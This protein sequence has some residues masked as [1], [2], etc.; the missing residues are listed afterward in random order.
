MIKIFWSFCVDIMK[1]FSQVQDGVESSQRSSGCSA[2]IQTSSPLVH[3]GWIC[4]ALVPSFYTEG[5]AEI[6]YTLNSITKTY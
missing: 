5:T 4:V 6:D 1:G 2:Y 3:P